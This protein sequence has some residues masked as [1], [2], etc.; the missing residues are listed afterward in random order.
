MEQ[1]DVGVIFILVKM[2]SLK[3]KQTQMVV[4]LR[5]ILNTVLT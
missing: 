3:M 1:C 2:F 5:K 4:K